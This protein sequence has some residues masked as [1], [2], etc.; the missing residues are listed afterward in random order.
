MITSNTKQCD[1]H[2]IFSQCGFEH[3]VYKSVMNK[4]QYTLNTFKKDVKIPN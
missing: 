4:K 3:K 2:W 1:L